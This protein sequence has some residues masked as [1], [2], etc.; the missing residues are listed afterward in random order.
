MMCTKTWPT[1]S[2][3]RSTMPSTSA[4]SRW[5]LGRAPPAGLAA[6]R[7]RRPRRRR[8]QTQ[9][10]G[11]RAAPPGGWG[12][13]QGAWGGARRGVPPPLACAPRRTPR[14]R[15][16]APSRTRPT[17]AWQDPNG[18]WRDIAVKEYAWQT[19]PAQHHYTANFDVRK[20]SGGGG[21]GAGQGKGAVRSSGT[22][23][24]WL[25]SFQA[26]SRQSSCQP[27]RCRA[28]LLGPMAHLSGPAPARSTCARK[29][30]P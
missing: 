27:P 6:R 8:P 11:P 18:F 16:H 10:R 23:A 3:G 24:P 14:P 1:S 30:L 17:R 26:G 5:V 2:P 29:P 7:E 15:S 22:L 9:T 4:P 19:E 12:G 28:R 25:P 20:A 13:R 21:I